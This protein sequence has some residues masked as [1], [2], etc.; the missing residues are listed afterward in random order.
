M[1]TRLETIAAALLTP[2]RLLS[3]QSARTT[4]L[5]LAILAAVPYLLH[6]EACFRADDFVVVADGH[7]LGLGDGLI[8]S[9][10][11]PFLDTRLS[12]FYRPLYRYA[13]V[14]LAHAFGGNALAYQLVNIAWHAFAVA[15]VSIFLRRL[16]GADAALYG[17]LLFLATPWAVNN[18]HWQVGAC[19]SV[20]TV[21]VVG[22]TLL[23]LRYVDRNRNGVPVGAI[24]A[25]AVGVFFRE[26]ALLAPFLAFCIDL[27]E[28]RRDLRAFRDWVLM[29]LPV[30]AYVA[31]RTAVLGATIGGYARFAAQVGEADGG[32][33]VQPWWWEAVGDSTL[34]LFVPGR[35]DVFQPFFFDDLRIAQAVVLGLF[36][37]LSGVRFFGKKSFLVLAAFTFAHAAPLMM[38]VAGIHASNSQRW[39]TVLWSLYGAMAVALTTGNYPRLR[40]LL[41]VGL[42]AMSVVRLETNLRHYD[43][44]TELTEVVLAE[45]DRHENDRI[46]VYNLP[47]AYKAAPLLLPGMSHAVGP[48]FGRGQSDVYAL[49]ASQRYGSDPR[50]MT[51]VA[52]VLHARGEDVAMIWVDLVTSPPR[53][54]KLPDAV[55]T[56][57]AAAFAAMPRLEVLEPAGTRVGP[58]QS[59]RVRVRADGLERIDLRFVTS[60]G[61]LIFRRHRDNNYPDARFE[62]T[63]EGD[64]FVEDVS[65]PL[66]GCWVGPSPANGRCWL[67]IVGYDRRDAVDPVASSDIIEI[68]V[69]RY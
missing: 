66:E 12:E 20:P 19:T 42:V 55:L 61:E 45:L 69:P 56:G 7:L 32:R 29:T 11:E 13:Y 43:E 9:F 51:P 52:P 4:A 14:L 62:V 23:Y 47:E 64:V 44:A 39:H 5:I 49:N 17:S 46:F 15:L 33:F 60:G 58:T 27:A 26:T 57:A 10:Q 2:L 22:T 6:P 53:A 18:V 37:V 30:V 21:T 35:G 36:F 34:D 50:A 65:Y 8:R 38:S 24:T 67:W 25:V 40:A 68:E 3:R 41:L 54:F 31:A 1:L 48:P 59:V 16:A 63:D 28:G